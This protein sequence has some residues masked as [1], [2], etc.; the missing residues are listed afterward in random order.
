MRRRSIGEQ[1]LAI[2]HIQT[3][4]TIRQYL[5]L[6][7]PLDACTYDDSLKVDFELIGQLTSF[8]QQFL[9]HLSYFAPLYL[10]IYEYTIHYPMILSFNNSTMR[11]LISSSLP[12]IVLLSLA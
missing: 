9:R 6:N 1:P 10:Y 12:V 11:P 7:I 8:G 4:N 3:V 5:L 2:E